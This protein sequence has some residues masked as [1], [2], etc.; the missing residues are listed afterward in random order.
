[1]TRATQ[2]IV[3]N[4]M[5]RVKVLQQLMGSRGGSVADIVGKIGISGLYQ[6]RQMNI[7]CRTLR[8][9]LCM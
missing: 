9:I 3:T 7:L 2:V 4:P 1:M 6:A 8:K 5:E